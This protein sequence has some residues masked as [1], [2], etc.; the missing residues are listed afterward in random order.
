M[1][2]VHAGS[3]LQPFLIGHA[4][5][6]R[7]QRVRCVSASVR[8]GQIALELVDLPGASTLK[9]HETRAQYES[10]DP[11]PPRIKLLGSDGVGARYIAG[12]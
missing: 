10:L 3:S 12:A 2:Y 4:A 5:G 8:F 9:E 1:Q 11:D 7:L 6:Q